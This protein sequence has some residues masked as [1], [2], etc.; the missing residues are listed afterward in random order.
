MELALNICET[1][2][3]CSDHPGTFPPIEEWEKVLGAETWCSCYNDKELSNFCGSW[4]DSYGLAVVKL[5]NGK[6]L[7]AQ[8]SSDT[9][10]MGEDA[11]VRYPCLIP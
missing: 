9:L 8:E 11:Q 6:F 2:T 10:D 7:V 4:C 5:K 3:R 1:A